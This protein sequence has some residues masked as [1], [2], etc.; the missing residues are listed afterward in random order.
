MTFFFAGNVLCQ[1]H[2]DRRWTGP[3]RRLC[4]DGEN[5]MA[6]D[7]WQITNLTRV[8]GQMCPEIMIDNQE[9]NWK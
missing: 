2:A 9:N 8:Y 4:Q 6:D 3:S 7:S 5:W 1:G